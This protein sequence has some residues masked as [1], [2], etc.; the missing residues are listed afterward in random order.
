MRVGD[1][2]LAHEPFAPPFEA[3]TIAEY[4]LF[5]ASNVAIKPA[6]MTFLQAAALPLAAGAAKTLVEAIDAQP[7]QVVLVNGASG[8]V[9]RFTVQMLAERGVTVIA[10]ASPARVDRMRELGAAEVIDYTLGPVSEQVRARYPEGVDALINLTGYTLEQVPLDAVRAGGTVRTVTRTPDDATL[11]ARGFAG[12]GVIA[13]PDGAVLRELAQQVVDG[14][15]VIDIA[16]V[17]PI[18]E[19]QRGLQDIEAGNAHGK[20]V[21]DMAL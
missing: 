13:S 2:V 1:E 8:G 17:L 9:G 4:A 14:D 18:E 19:A 20:L 16:R 3:G 6:E 15:L 21:V 10:T 11:A 5:P 12:G 7:G